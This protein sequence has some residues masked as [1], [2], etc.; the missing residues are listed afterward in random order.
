MK[1]TQPLR[2]VSSIRTRRSRS[3]LD[4]K[5]KILQDV[6]NTLT[7]ELSRT[8]AFQTSNYLQGVWDVAGPSKK[9][10]GAVVES[11]KLD[12]EILDRWIKYMDKKTDKYHNKDAWQ[13]MMKSKNGGTQAEAKKLADKFQEEVVEA[14]LD[15]TDLDAQNQ[16]IKDKD[17]AGNQAEEADRQA[18]QLRH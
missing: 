10:K 6:N 14:L 4:E 2:R 7:A 11:R 8:Y 9:E 3:R 13:A 1:S 5:N 12:Y 15:K 16:I 18:Q 17:V